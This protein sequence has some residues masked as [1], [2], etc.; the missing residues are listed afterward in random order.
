V[1]SDHL[2]TIA[3]LPDR[4]S[5]SKF[6]ASANDFIVLD[7][8]TGQFTSAAPI[9]AQ[10]LCSH[11]Y[12]VGADG[13]ILIEN[14]KK[15]SFRVRYYNP[16]GQEF[17][18]CGNGGRCAVRYAFLSVISGRKMN[19]ETNVGVIDAEVIGSSVRIR[20]VSPSRFTLNVPIVVDGQALK[21]HFVRLGEPHFLLYVKDIRKH[22]IVPLAR[23]IRYHERFQPEGTNVH[24]IEP[25]DRHYV[26][27]RSYERGVEDETLACGSGCISSAIA[28]YAT[29]QTVPP[30]TF[31]PQSGI[32]VTVHFPEDSNFRELYLEGDARLV[33]RGELT[34]EALLGFP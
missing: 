7:N 8:R 21:G 9:L 10:R 32:P 23:K 34:K 28:T 30:I 2:E 19:L 33:Y 14:S 31:E 16:D 24:F 3:Q 18:T 6:S 20:F 25:M 22:S 29:N 13:L 1:N 26:K 27:I 12:S 11:R 5:F 15:A 4:I 17:N